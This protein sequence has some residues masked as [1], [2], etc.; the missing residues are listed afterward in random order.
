MAFDQ[1]VYSVSESVW[2]HHKHAASCAALHSRY[3]E[4]LRGERRLIPLFEHN[5]T[6]VLVKV[7]AEARREEDNLFQGNLVRELLHNSV[8]CSFWD[9]TLTWPSSWQR[10]SQTC[11]ARTLI[12]ASAGLHKLCVCVCVLTQNY[13]FEAQDM[14][15][16]V[17]LM[18]HLDVLRDCHANLTKEGY[19]LPPF[20]A[21]LAEV[22]ESTSLVS[23]H[24]RIAFH[25]IYELVKDFFVSF[26]YNGV[27][28]RF[29]PSTLNVLPEA[30][31]IVRS[32]MPPRKP[33][34]QLG[35]TDVANAFSRIFAM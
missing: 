7:L 27:T 33:A 25:V 17:E 26:N 23:F 21:L 2:N 11:S 19:L 31:R 3:A 22:D 14:T 13:R 6:H 12:T 15:N 8:M 32:K 34:F 29:V 24:G 30:D 18:M 4:L 20:D 1:L 9:A 28:Q 10:D 16:V 35:N 5:M